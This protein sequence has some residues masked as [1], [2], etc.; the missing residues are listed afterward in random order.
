MPAHSPNGQNRLRVPK[1][2]G[3]EECQ[4]LEMVSLCLTVED[5]FRWKRAANKACLSLSE[6]IRKKC[7]GQKIVEPTK[8]RQQK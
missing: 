5:K 8:W 2:Q 4:A 3:G 1:M 6:W 7:N